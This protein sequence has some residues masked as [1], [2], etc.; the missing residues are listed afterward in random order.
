[1][2]MG[3]EINI[4]DRCTGC[5][6][7]VSL[8]PA[9]AI[10]L[11]ISDEGFWYPSVNKN[12]CV[13]CGKCLNGCPVYRGKD[14]KNFLLPVSYAGWN[15]DIEEH[16]NSSSGGIFSLIARGFLEEGGAVYGAAYNDD[17]RVEHIRIDAVTELDRLRRSKYVQSYISK[18]LLHSLK[19]DIDSGKKVLFSGTPCQ[20]ASVNK[21]YFQYDNLLTV[22]V[23]C[24]GV[25][26]PKAW[27]S[28]L[29][30]IISKH[31][32]I[33]AINM[34][35]KTSGWK[36]IF[37]QTEY[38]DGLVDESWFNDN[39]WGESFVKNL[40]LRKSCYKCEFKENIRCSDISLGDF[41]EAARGVHKEL[42]DHDRGTSII[43][44]NSEKGKQAF[45]KLKSKDVC[46]FKNIP[47]HWIPKNT[48]A[49]TKSSPFNPKRD[50]A[51]MLLD[52]ESFSK[53]IEKVSTKIGR[54]KT[55]QTIKT[56]VKKSILHRSEDS[57]SDGTKQSRFY[58]IDADV[59]I[60]NIQE[61]DNYGAVLLCFA[62]QKAIEDLGYK[63]RVIDFRPVDINKSV[64]YG[65]RLLKKIK[66]KGF[67]G[68]SVAI[69]RKLSRK[70]KVGVNISSDLKKER[71]EQFRETYLKRT[72]IYNGMSLTDSP[73][74]KT[75]VVGSDVVW[76]PARV[77]SEEADT[78]FLTFTEGLLC[79]RVAYAASIGTDDA[80]TLEKIAPLFQKYIEKFNY[81]SLR[82]RTSISFVKELYNKDVTWCMDPTLLLRKE[83]YDR[84]FSLDSK[85]I[86]GDYIY[87]YLFESNEAVYKMVNEYSSELGIPVICQCDMPDR[88]SNL[89]EFSSDDGP[90]DFI[91]RIKNARMV[92]TDSFHGTVFSII[93]QKDFITL[94]RGNISIRMK[95]LLD[96]LNLLCRYVDT[97]ETA[98]L[99]LS[100]IDY[101]GITQIIDAWREESMDYLR[102][103]LEPK[104]I[105]GGYFEA[106]ITVIA[107][108]E[109]EPLSSGKDWKVAA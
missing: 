41:W 70:G 45:D 32:E 48:Y 56:S 98:H 6:I 17:F 103:A 19:K 49:V 28:Y 78:Y 80:K 75:Y 81:V 2:I 82:E 9:D 50:Q 47:Y 73:L 23:V 68:T 10:A 72:P 5:N 62:L 31:G 8:C 93:Y 1:M 21:L 66:K 94:S 101:V 77:M 88:I 54:L 104:E 25:P 83:D 51:F 63:V 7:C 26:S 43:L 27:D 24:H 91:S 64:G 102:K 60:L 34:R 29:N 107:S 76:K 79:N 40:F 42:D 106:L 69:I 57:S 38:T 95:D 92:I 33:K 22:D 18:E 85:R 108:A 74:F 13:E 109:I 53:V 16:L 96:R 59:G 14:E 99:I 35:K 90:I 3:K 65:K 52:A 39:V 67:V 11:K 87:F 30:E 71:F 55:L 15:K 100:P 105:G 20:V 36:K 86:E 58:G 37:F 89:K 46:F 61:V 84:C 97:P 12:K 4:D 44:I